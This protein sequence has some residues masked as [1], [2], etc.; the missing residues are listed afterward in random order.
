VERLIGDDV[1]EQSSVVANRAMNRERG[2][3]GRDGYSR[4][5]GVDVPGLLSGS[6]RWLDLCCGSGKALFEAAAML[7]SVEIT[8]VDLVDFFA[9]PAP[10]SVSLHVG[11]IATWEPVGAFDL[12]TCVHGLHYVGDKLA[13]LSRV[14]S[15]LR[16]DGLFV[17]N[18][19]AASVFASGVPAGRR[20]TG[21][22][23]QAGFVYDSRNRRIQRRGH[24]AVELP[25]QYLGA[26]DH[27]G[28]NYTGQ[29]AVHSHYA[30]VGGNGA[31]F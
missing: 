5:L 12:I 13:V 14:A 28:P 26:D 23:R 1:L 11:S 16:D 20:L 30:T 3:S 8:G 10:A 31:D 7:P 9:G 4:V 2:L 24:G 19:D 29:P 22:L 15:W 17:A 21:A 18:F 6:A 25:F 27:A